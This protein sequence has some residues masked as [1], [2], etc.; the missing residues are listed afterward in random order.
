MLAASLMVLTGGLLM[1]APKPAEAAC[2]T[3]CSQAR[4]ACSNTCAGNAACLA[5]CR[6]AYVDCCKF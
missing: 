2:P 3:Y 6:D 5:D 4:V 1:V